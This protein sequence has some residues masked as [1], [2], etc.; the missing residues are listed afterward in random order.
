VQWNG[1]DV[2]GWTYNK[3]TAV[4]SQAGTVPAGSIR[5]NQVNAVE[6]K[7]RDP[8]SLQKLGISSEARLLGI[9]VNSVSLTA[10]K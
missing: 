3:D 9:S 6:L 7:I 2:L 4:F 10:E 5:C 8:Q 1:Q